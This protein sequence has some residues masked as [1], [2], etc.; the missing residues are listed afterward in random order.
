MPVKIV[1][2]LGLGKKL[3][4]TRLFL[5][6]VTTFIRILL[7]VIASVH[8]KLQSTELSTNNGHGKHFREVYSFLVKTSNQPTTALERSGCQQIFDVYI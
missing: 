7:I 8:D 5:V 4:F 2:P 3:F 6:G 1:R